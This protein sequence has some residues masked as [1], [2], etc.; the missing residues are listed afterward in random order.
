MD[1]TV[2]HTYQTRVSVRIEPRA[3]R[4][5][6]GMRSS[7]E[8]SGRRDWAYPLDVITEDGECFLSRFTEY[9][10]VECV[11]IPILHYVKNSKT[12]RS[13]CWMEAVSLGVG[14]YEPPGP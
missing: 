3:A 2:I 12:T 10:T 8:R 4:K 6:R 7:V 1:A 11:K 5:P 13:S 14:R 9:V